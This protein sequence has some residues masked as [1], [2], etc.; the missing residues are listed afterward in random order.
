MQSPFVSAE[1]LAARLDDP[2]TVIVDASWYLPAANRDPRAEY[3]AG[4][5]PGAVFFDIDGIADR[6]S[7]LPHMLLAPA[8]FARAVG[9]MGIG[10]GATIVVYDGAGLSSASRVWWNFVIM[11]ATDVRILEGGRPGGRPK[12]GR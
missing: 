2:G 8:D 1:W 3:L 5:I 12:A 10:D 9:E 4:H 6:S 7:G 11:G